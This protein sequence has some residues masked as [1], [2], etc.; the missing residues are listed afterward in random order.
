MKLLPRNLKE[1]IMAYNVDGTLN[2]KGTIKQFVKLNLDILG[3]TYDTRLLI[4][5]LGK[6]KI[7]LGFPWL[8]LTNPEINWQTGDFQWRD[9]P[10]KQEQTTAKTPIP[11]P[12]VEDEEDEEEWMN[13]TV[14]AI[15]TD[16]SDDSI[17]EVRINHINICVINEDEGTMHVI[18]GETN[19][20]EIWI[21]TK[22]NLALEMAIKDNLAKEER[23]TEE[24][25]PKEFH[26]YLDIFNEKNANRFPTERPWDHKIELKENFEPKSFKIYNL[27]PAEQQELDT[28][29]KENLEKG[30]IRPSQSPMASPFFFVKKKDGKLRPCQDYRYLNDWTIKNAYPL[31]LIS[32]IMDKLKGSKY[33]TKLDVRWGYNN[34]RIKKGDEWKAAF[35]TNRGLFEPTVMFFGMTNSPATFQSMMDSI[36]EDMIMAKEVII[37][38]DDILIFTDTLEKL[39]R[40]TKIVLERLEDYDLYLKPKKCE[41]NKK[42]IE[43]L[44]MIVEEGKL[45]MD[46][47][48]LGG[49]RDWPI[50]STV[51]QVR[52]FLGF[53]NFYR[54]FIAHYSDLA[55]PLIDLTKK[56]RKFEWTDE[57]QT[58]FELLKKKFTEEPVLLLPDHS[59]PF[60]IESDASK[61][62][63]GAVLTQLDANGDR[64]PCAFLS[65]TLSPTEQNYEIYDRELPGIV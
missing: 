60:Q 5:G 45:S 4:T 16:E 15:E 44:G 35:K 59:R 41:F 17:S 9:T 30:Y 39:E 11:K 64:Y 27:S 18:D 1:P 7:I 65:K 47:V 21:N 10:R 52:S 25:V 36:F 31:P 42:R 24:L 54:K 37:Y 2:K 32:D 46:P 50:P 19:G 28:F 12:T 23:T 51:K 33:F 8:Q 40:R 26:E 29:L 20:S 43:Y 61:V 38:M 49:I 62:A 48:K 3:K 56:D 13:H 6:Q 34:I 22:T 58:T 63:T 53:G 57:C 14:N 55:R